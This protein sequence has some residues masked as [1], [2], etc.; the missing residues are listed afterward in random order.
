MKIIIVS[1]IVLT[2]LTSC[3]KKSEFK[4]QPYETVN[5]KPADKYYISINDTLYDNPEAYALVHGGKLFTTVI[6]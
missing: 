2:S 5:V 6:K 1:L 4:N 3:V